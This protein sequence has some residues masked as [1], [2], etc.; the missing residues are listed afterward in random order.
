M[1][2]ENVGEGG[3]AGKGPQGGGGSRRGCRA[4]REREGGRRQ[5]ELK[6]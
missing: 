2:E 5:V 4:A 3:R 6:P 1:L